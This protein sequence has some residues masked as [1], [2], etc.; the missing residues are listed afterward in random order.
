M[1]RLYHMFA[2]H[3]T[4]RVTQVSDIP[5]PYNYARLEM[6]RYGDRRSRARHQSPGIESLSLQPSRLHWQ[7]I[8]C[9]VALGDGRNGL[10]QS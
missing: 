10:V 7:W 8:D 3:S 1:P 5:L 6:A 4:G 2:T 9:A